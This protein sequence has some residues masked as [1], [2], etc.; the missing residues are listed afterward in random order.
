MKRRTKTPL[1]TVWD[2]QTDTYSQ[3]PKSEL[4]PGM[5][6]LNLEGRG[7]VWVRS[8]QCH[9]FKQSPQ[10]GYDF[11]DVMEIIAEIQAA[12]LPYRGLT[13][14]EWVDG[15]QRDQNPER[16]IAIWAVG[17]EKM[18]KY[19][20]GEPTPR[21]RE[22]YRLIINAMVNGSDGAL[23]TFSAEHLSKDEISRILGPEAKGGQA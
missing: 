6:S 4:A 1:V 17:A 3:I 11:S 22:V 10:K 21:N 15:F 16:E 9:D 2:K 19:A 13:L 23:Q 8:D 18:R 20:P 5:I 14:Q 7:I 12:F